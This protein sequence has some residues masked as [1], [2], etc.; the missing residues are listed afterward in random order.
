MRAVRIGLSMIFMA[1][2]A[3]SAALACPFDGYVR[4]DGNH[5][6]QLDG[7]DLGV[8]GIVVTVQNVAGTWSDT[9]VTDANGY[10][11]MSL[12]DHPDCYHATIDTS[13]LPAGGAVLVPASN[14]LDFCVSSTDQETQADWLIQS[15]ACQAGQCWMTGG[16]TVYEPLTNSYLATK[17]T[18]ITFGGNVHPGCSATAGA[19]GDWNHVDRSRKLHFH[20]TTIPNVSCGNVPGIP[21][22]STSPKTPFNYIEYDGTGWVHGLQG[23]KYNNDHV[24]FYARVE[25]RNEPGSNGANAGALIDRYFLRVYTNQFDPLGSTII[26]LDSDNGGGLE[27]DVTPINS[28]NLQIH[29]SSCDNPPLQ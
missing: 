18:K 13:S 27:R 8:A 10:Y 2:V 5:N 16:G 4:C 14:T 1:A 24:F 29:V 26:L 20:G 19:G 3:G 25:D 12:Q 15:D 17:G 23:N 11:L 9:D 6:G 22:G 7:Q 21:P 28:G